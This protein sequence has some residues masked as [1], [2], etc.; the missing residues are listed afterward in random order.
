LHSTS[1][2]SFIAKYSQNLCSDLELTI[3]SLKNSN[4]FS[5]GFSFGHLIGGERPY[6][7]N[8]NTVPVTNDSLAIFNLPGIYQ[9]S[10]SDNNNCARTSSIIVDGVSEISN[11]D[12]I[13]NLISTNHR[14]GFSSFIW[15]DAFNDGCLPASGSLQLI[16]DTLVVYSTAFPPPDNINGDTLIW[17]FTDILY[18]SAHVM[19]Y[20]VVQTNASAGIGDTICYKLIINPIIGDADTINNIKEYC[21]PV[22]N[23]YD[24]NDKKVYPL[25]LCS[26][27][28]INNNEQLTYTIRFQN[29]GNAEAI[30]IYILDTLSINLDLYSVRTIGSSHTLITEVLP[31]NV[32]KFRFDNINLPDSTSNEALSHGYVVFEVLQNAGLSNGITITNDVG[33]YFDFNP[34]VYTNTVLNTIS[35]GTLNTNIFVTGNTIT[36]AFNG[37]AYQWLDCDNNNA[38][39][40]GSTNQIFSPVQNGNYSVI[41]SDGCFADTSVCVSM[42]MTDINAVGSNAQFSF[43]PNPSD[44]TITFATSVTTQIKI[45]DMLGNVIVESLINDK[46]VIDISAFAKGI[47]FIQNQEGYTSKLIRQ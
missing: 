25:G 9:F 4:C 29:T 21:F 44:N 10:V 2:A 20:V 16:L 3:D 12:L 28:F 19:P 23:G 26:E 37:A 13:A 17:N 47:Y 24:P 43:Y 34:P 15:L 41:I 14:V 45:F 32:L 35:D 7:Y 38:I 30:N 11:F 1:G 8:W 27:G 39:V 33:I 46:S 6:N 18:D 36:A 31:G 22:I 5:S 40:P 42:I